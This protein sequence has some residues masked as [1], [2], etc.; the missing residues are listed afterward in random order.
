MPII[1]AIHSGAKT[2]LAYFHYAC[3]GQQP[4][5][6]KHNWS[7]DEAKNMAHLD[8]DQTAFVKKCRRLIENNGGFT[9]AYI[10]RPY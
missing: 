3:K 5:S 6:P 7:K 2:I 8:K 4:F 10:R 9:R 1:N